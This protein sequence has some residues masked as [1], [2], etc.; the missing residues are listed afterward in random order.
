MEE[1]SSGTA[2]D[3]PTNRRRKIKK[4]EGG[5]WVLFIVCFNCISPFPAPHSPFFQIYAKLESVLSYFMNIFQRRSLCL[6]SKLTEFQA[7][8]RRLNL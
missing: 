1:I 4:E 2:F 5:I 3:H 8:Q 7:Q 6:P